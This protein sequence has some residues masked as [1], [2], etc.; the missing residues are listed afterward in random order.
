MKLTDYERILREA[1]FDISLDFGC[2]D[3]EFSIEMARARELGFV[4]PDEYLDENFSVDGWF[5]MCQNVLGQNHYI[6]HKG[7]P[8]F[9]FSLGSFMEMKICSRK[10]CLEALVNKLTNKV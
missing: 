9:V 1:G 8:G 4:F 2:V 6:A 7:K 3:L 5:E 10:R